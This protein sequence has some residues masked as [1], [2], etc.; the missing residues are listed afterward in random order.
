[1]NAT[2]ILTRLK[3]HEGIGAD[4]RVGVVSSFGKGAEVITKERTRD[5]VVIANTGDIDLDNE[6]VVPSGADTGYFERNKMIF[7][8]HLYDL[9]QVAGRMRTLEKY[10]SAD[11]HKA[12]RVRAHIAD[13][14]I[15]NTVRTI[16][17]ETG[18]IGVSIGFVADDYGPPTDDERKAYKAADGS[19]PQSVV[20]SWKWFELSFTALPCNVA[21]QSMTVTEGKSLDMLNAVD[22]LVTKGVIDRDSAARLGMPITAKRRFHAVGRKTLRPMLE[23]R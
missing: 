21:C 19:T 4:D 3:A 16:V 15:G 12:W 11:N 20:R 22:E 18:Q 17:E 8:D 1:M 9:N 23:V 2:T 5:I 7:A 6:V 13:N 14:P 10:P